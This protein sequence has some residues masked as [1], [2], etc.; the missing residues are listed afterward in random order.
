MLTWRKHSTRVCITLAFIF[1]SV[2]VLSSCRKNDFG[3]SIKQD[4]VVEKFLKVPASATAEVNR[5][6]E[7]LK[8]LNQKS[9]FINEIAKE[10]FALWDKAIVQHKNATAGESEHSFVIIPL[11]PEN[12]KQVTAFLLAKLNDTVSIKLYRANDYSGY[13]HG[14]LHDKEMNAE[15]LAMQFML[16]EF[17]TFG[18]TEFKIT[19]KD[20]FK[21]GAG[22]AAPHK[23]RITHIQKTKSPYSGRGGSFE[24]WEYEVCTTTS[25]YSCNQ[26]GACCAS[27]G[28]PIGSCSGCE[29]QCWSSSTTC[30]RTSILVAVDDGWYPSGGG[31][32]TGGGGGGGSTGGSGN[33]DQYQC[34][35]FPDLDNGL[36]PCPRGNTTG[37]VT[38]LEIVADPSTLGDFEDDPN[39]FEDDQTPITFDFS[40]DPWPTISNVL[41]PTHFVRYDGRNCLALAKDQIGKVGATDLGYGSAHKV[42]DASGGPYPS[43]AKSGVDYIITKLKQGR[44]VIVGVDNR[45][46]TPSTVNAD[47]KTDHFVVIVGT[48]EDSQGKYFTFFDNATNWVSNG[49][50]AANKL[51][52]DP[53]T[54]MIT[55]K[56]SVPGANDSPNYDYIVTQIRKN[57]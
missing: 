22:S 13:E 11:A 2:L 18:N 30:V 53:A 43:V 51:Y 33:Y 14:H 10:G 17:E 6:A 19:D 52:Y 29:N 8:S 57:N 21:M 41:G 3:T 15:K 1:F 48:G 7:K 5:V 44:P 28:V 23:D 40:T 45:P 4:D 46:G 36:P 54:G 47:G 16:L 27:L 32:S 49:A 35:P 9:G 42:F 24:V 37:W 31:G 38:I 12:T 39:V 20:L 26:N 56:S 50:S 25:S 55:G 34:N